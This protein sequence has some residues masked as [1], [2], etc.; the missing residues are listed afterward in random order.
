MSGVELL[1]RVRREHPDVLTMMLTAHADMEV[2]LRAMN[3]L[4]V[5][6]YFLK[7]WSAENLRAA[8]R[9]GIELRRQS[10]GAEARNQKA[11]DQD[12][13]L[14]QWEKDQPGITKVKRDADGVYI[15][16]PEDL[17]DANPVGDPP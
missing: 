17:G 13:I 14:R 16:A 10:D 2:V 12:A 7:P 4:G 5:Y 15:L 1:E 8:I 9:R 3:E 11:R 6:K